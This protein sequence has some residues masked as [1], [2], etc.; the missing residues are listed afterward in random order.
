MTR[1]VLAVCRSHKKKRGDAAAILDRYFWRIGD[2]T[3]RGYAS[4]ACLERVSKDL[5]AKAS[6]NMAVSLFELKRGHGSMAPLFVV[7][8][9]AAF[10]QEGLCAIRTSS[11]TQ[12][13]GELPD[14]EVAFRAI[15]DIAAA[16]HDFGKATQMFQDKL[17]RSSEAKHGIADPVRH[18]VISAFVVD[19]IFGDAADDRAALQSLVEARSDRFSAAFDAVGQRALS[20]FMDEQ[21]SQQKGG[22]HLEFNHLKPSDLSDGGAWS[23]RAAVLALILSHHRLPEIERDYSVFRAGDLVEGRHEDAVSQDAFALASGVPPWQDERWQAHLNHAADRLLGVADLDRALLH[24]PDPALIGR[25]ALM[26]ADHHGSMSKEMLPGVSSEGVLLANTDMETGARCDDLVMHT[27]RVMKTARHT[28]R[29]VLHDVKRLPGLPISRCPE[30][31]WAPPKSPGRFAWQH[32]AAL[33]AGKA[34]TARPGGFFGCI[35]A[36]TGA[37][38]T[39]GAPTVLASA[40]YNDPDPGR[41]SLRFALGLG[42][43][44]LA[45]QSGAEYVADLGFAPSDVATMVGGPDIDASGDGLDE[46]GGSEDR[47]IDLQDLEVRPADLTAPLDGDETPEWIAGLG[48][49]SDEDLPA[50]LAEIIEESGRKSGDLHRLIATP[51]LAATIDHFMPAADARRGRHVLQSLRV[52]SSDLILDEI[53]LYEPEDLAAIARLVF[54]S[55]LSGRRVIVMSASLPQDVAERL[56]ASYSAGWSQY[57]A[58]SD[59]PDHVNCLLCGDTE[60]SV[61]VNDAN[62]DFSTLYQAVRKAVT[63]NLAT[64]PALRRSM[65]LPEASDIDSLARTISEASAELHAQHAVKCGDIDVSVGL[66][67]MTRIDHLQRLALKLPQVGVLEVGPDEDTSDPAGNVGQALGPDLR[68]C[69]VLHS[70]MPMA[71]RLHIERMLRRALTRKDASPNDGVSWLVDYMGLRDRMSATGARSVSIVVLSS[72]VIETGND[73]DFD[74]AIVDPSSLRAILQTA[75]RVNRHRCTPITAPNIALLPRPLVTTLDGG[76]RLQCP[77]VE[78][79]PGGATGVQPIVLDCDRSLDGG[80]IDREVL[81]TIDARLCL[82]ADRGGV[83]SAAEETMRNRFAG[84]F[85]CLSV[86]R[87][88]GAARFAADY[89][90][91]RKFRRSDDIAV[92]LVPLFRMDEIDSWSYRRKRDRFEVSMARPDIRMPDGIYRGPSLADLLS[93]YTSGDGHRLEGSIS[94]TGRELEIRQVQLHAELG[95]I[96]T[97]TL[98]KAKQ[99]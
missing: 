56:H 46:E 72:P 18:E 45:R 87:D 26:L 11:A 92:D 94:M 28:A 96:R 74:W 59:A 60:N 55:G 63:A 76:D 39:R 37:G 51:I 70:R 95:V 71:Q 97:K 84:G 38:K 88:N 78:T 86:F 80:L 68:A 81:D 33:A 41:Q 89:G 98:E 47:L 83:W 57:A 4:N 99:D 82:D 77:G 19:E 21:K 8:R 53:D 36:G 61:F 79:E 9:K 90:L 3:W 48:Y 43:R 31:V 44:T 91:R 7:G 75:G 16:C 34:V 6:R 40:T 25:T 29:L 64:A 50:T 1:Q 27:S 15:L 24:L 17:R 85:P 32:A 52:M 14:H 10:S 13:G 73:I 22:R 65:L 30:A 49:D 5:K 23:V 12:A 2:R 67:R 93:H 66:V 54:L 62:Q 69:I 58:R 42:L 35:L 20:V